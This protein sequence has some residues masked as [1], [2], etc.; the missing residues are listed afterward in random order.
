MFA[1]AD[2]N[3]ISEA[4][5]QN[6][7]RGIGCAIFGPKHSLTA[8]GVAVGVR[9]TV[10]ERPSA[11]HG[12]QIKKPT[13]TEIAA[14][15]Q[16][17][18]DSLGLHLRTRPVGKVTI[19]NLLIRGGPNLVQ[20]SQRSLVRFVLRFPVAYRGDVPTRTVSATGNRDVSGPIRIA[21]HAGSGQVVAASDMKI[22]QGSNAGLGGVSVVRA[23]FRC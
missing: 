22:A 9:G 6:N 23:S 19:N 13:L 10:A 1:F 16:P 17:Q 20:L 18:T 11:T 14:S 3:S 7:Q 12:Q 15:N 21:D 4:T 5:P 2:E 8:T